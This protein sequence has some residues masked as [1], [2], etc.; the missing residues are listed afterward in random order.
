M[1]RFT[2]AATALLLIASVPADSAG[3]TYYKLSQS[4]WWTRSQPIAPTPS[5]THPVVKPKPSQRP[6]LESP[7]RTTRHPRSAGP[8]INDA[9]QRTPCTTSGAL[10]IAASIHGHRAVCPRHDMPETE[11]I[12]HLGEHTVCLTTP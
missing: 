11:H 7:Q 3:L 10:L 9:A 8:C 6:A 12:R 2:H 4:D 5:S 1:R